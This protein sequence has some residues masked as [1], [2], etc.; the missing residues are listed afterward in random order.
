MYYTFYNLAPF[1]VTLTLVISG[2]KKKYVMEPMASQPIEDN[3]N[4]NR[5]DKATVDMHT[6]PQQAVELAM[7]DN[8]FRLVDIEGQYIS[9]VPMFGE[10]GTMRTCYI[11]AP[12]QPPAPRIIGEMETDLPGS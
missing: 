12:Y 1:A 6:I 4:F 10:D 8:K 3:M 2:K 9:N 5:G 11:I 7:V